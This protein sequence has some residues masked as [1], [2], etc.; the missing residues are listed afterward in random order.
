MHC[1]IFFYIDNKLLIHLLFDSLIK[2]V[3]SQGL[4]H[5]RRLGNRRHYWFIFILF[6]SYFLWVFIYKI[7]IYF[8]WTCTRIWI[9]F[10]QIYLTLG[11]YP[12][13]YYYFSQIKRRSS[14]IP[15]RSNGTP[16]RS[17]TTP[18][19]SNGTPHRSLALHVGAIA[20]HVGVMAL[21]IGVIALQV[22]VIALHVGVIALQVG[23]M[24][25]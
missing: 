3:N 19:M 17:N 20:L 7:L 21:H 18:R 24:A 12:N 10:K 6:C 11:L 15:C 1:V 5:S 23:V 13:K 2:H 8:L 22:G 25:L 16:H 4:F 14:G 9:L